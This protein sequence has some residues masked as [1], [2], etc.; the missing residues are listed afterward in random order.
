MTWRE[1]LHRYFIIGSK[2]HF[3]YTL[4]GLIRLEK[5]QHNI[6]EEEIPYKQ[7]NKMSNELT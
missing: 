1:K 7:K 4:I 3:G 5:V 2:L 6:I